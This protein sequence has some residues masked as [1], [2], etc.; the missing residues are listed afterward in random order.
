MPTERTAAEAEAYIIKS[1]EYWKLNGLDKRII[2]LS[3]W[4]EHWRV[5]GESAEI[6][7]KIKILESGMRSLRRLIDNNI[8]LGMDTGVLQEQWQKMFDSS[9]DLQLNFNPPTK[10]TRKSNV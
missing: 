3:N 10:R 4:A 6:A 5:S 9:N 8:K 7:S 1:I 2:S